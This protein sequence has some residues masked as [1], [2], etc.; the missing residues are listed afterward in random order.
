MTVVVPLAIVVANPLV[1]LPKVAIEGDA[2]QTARAVVSCIEPSVNVPRAVN[3]CVTPAGIETPAGATD[4][5]E[6]GI[7]GVTASVAEPLTPS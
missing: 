7:A 4:A 3:G 6:T 1:V 5:T 2:L